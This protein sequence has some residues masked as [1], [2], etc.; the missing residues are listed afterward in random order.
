MLTKA[1]LLARRVQEFN[2]GLF[3]YL[4]AT[5]DVHAAATEQQERPTGGK[6]Q[7][8]RSKRSRQGGPRKDEEFGVTRGI[9]FKGVA[10]V[11]NFDLPASVQG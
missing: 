1:L 7:G 10:T 4:I 9:D 3:D 5:D 11:V 6:R 2:R 8:S